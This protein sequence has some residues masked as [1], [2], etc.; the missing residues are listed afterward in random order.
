MSRQ[1]TDA[2]AHTHNI[3]FLYDGA[4]GGAVVGPTTTDDGRWRRGWPPDGYRGTAM[5]ATIQTRVG[6]FPTNRTVNLRTHRTSPIGFPFPS[7]GSEQSTPPFQAPSSGKTWGQWLQLLASSEFQ[8]PHSGHRLRN[9]PGTLTT[10]TTAIMLT[11]ITRYVDSDTARD[12]PRLP[13]G[14]PPGG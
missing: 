2:A 6:E 3:A 8:A 5:G 11:I 14:R 12:A 1:K 4:A 9:N 10:A 7:A 13:S